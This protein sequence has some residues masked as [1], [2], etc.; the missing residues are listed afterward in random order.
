VSS[1]NVVFPQTQVGQSAT[2]GL[3]LQNTGVGILT[4]TVPSPAA[5]F[6]V[7]S[8]GGSFS[9]A[10]QATKAVT[11]KFAPTAPGHVT[12][13][14]GIES[15]DPTSPV[16]N[17]GLDGTGQDDIRAT[18]GG[19]TDLVLSGCQDPTDDGPYSLRG[20]VTI[21]TQSGTAFSGFAEMVSPAFELGF[22]TVSGTLGSGNAVSGT[23]SYILKNGDT[24]TSQ[25][26]G[27]FTGTLTDGNLSLDV[28]GHDTAGDTCRGI[29]TL[30]GQDLMRG[31]VAF[32]G[33]YPTPGPIAWLDGG[34]AVNVIGYPG[35]VLLFVD[36]GVD[37]TTAHGI[38]AA[39]GGTILAQV[40]RAHYY[41]VGVTAGNEQ[42]FMTS[43]L[44]E[45]RVLYALPNLSVTDQGT[46][47]VERDCSSSH[48]TKV[49][50]EY[51]S[52]AGG[53]APPCINGPTVD[54]A[55]FAI[56]EAA[57]TG[58]GAGTFINLS[59]GPNPSVDYR[60]YDIDGDGS[61]TEQD[62]SMFQENWKTV[63]RSELG[64]IASIP[65]SHRANLVMTI[66]T[67]NSNMPL[68]P[69]LEDI[70]QDPRLATVLRNNVTLVTTE[71]AGAPSAQ[72]P[73]GDFANDAPDDPDVVAVNN[74]AA[75]DGTSFAAPSLLGGMVNTI[76]IVRALTGA[77]TETVKKAVQ[78]AVKT[79]ANHQ[80][81]ESE[82]EDKTN[83]I[84]D[85][86]STDPANASTVTTI[87]FIS[88][89]H[90]TAALV[91][92]PLAGVSVQFTVSG[93]DG[94]YNSGTLQTNTAGSVSFLIPPGASG[95]RDTI[96]V[97][98]LLSGAVRVTQFT[99]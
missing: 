91:S 40:P 35:Q 78:L 62:Q 25:G 47:V 93:T 56:Y 20:G 88:V 33:T 3:T 9:L 7:Q 54:L 16:R 53:T 13:T 39:H 80:V 49:K 10:P 27:T 22:G 68:S 82:V 66:A 14:L 75:V 48:A 32:A 69:M 46:T 8:G 61:A 6:S 51:T 77:P 98:A 30:T 72:Y 84:L 36:S 87:T 71:R 37:A 79:N 86:E 63:L 64:A 12:G 99:W 83:A 96:S 55:V 29:G 19:T 89:G 70:R 95:V 81:V 94:Y 58:G 15:N 26:Q 44:S 11:L 24:I 92:P 17:V 31:A 1:V 41:L 43:A 18:Y 60:F 21:T 85:A 67:G 59:A 74:P 34:T 65:D 57:G 52:V 45:S 90:T 50:T 76:A 4:G 73:T 97:S 5:P 28:D 23:F 2:V 38:V 42:A